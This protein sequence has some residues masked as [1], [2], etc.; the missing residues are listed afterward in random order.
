MSASSVG[1]VS[2]AFTQ[3]GLIC[4]QRSG[5]APGPWR[6]RL[7]GQEEMKFDSG[8]GYRSSAGVSA[9]L[10]LGRAPGLE[11]SRPRRAEGSG[12]T[13]P[14]ISAVRGGSVPGGETQRSR[15]QTL[16]P[17]LVSGLH[18][19]RMNVTQRE[20]RPQLLS[21]LQP[22][23]HRGGEQPVQGLP[24]RRRSPDSD[25]GRCPNP[26]CEPAGLPSMRNLEGLPRGKE[27]GEI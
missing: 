16:L 22:L 1:T 10:E 26:S 21:S 11:G 2:G 27:G 12:E 5:L 4:Q 6:S 7:P 24:A 18:C 20:D 19:Q 14:H 3:Q 25:S 23:R 13:Q 15:I 17:G 8:F 9:E